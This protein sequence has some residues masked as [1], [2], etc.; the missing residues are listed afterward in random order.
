MHLTRR[1]NFKPD[2]L[3]RFKSPVHKFRGKLTRRSIEECVVSYSSNQ[4]HHFSRLFNCD[5]FHGWFERGQLMA[6]LDDHKD[7]QNGQKYL[8]ETYDPVVSAQ[9]KVFP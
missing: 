7:D 3:T 9:V 4:I 5:R 2:P 8:N 1:V 6:D